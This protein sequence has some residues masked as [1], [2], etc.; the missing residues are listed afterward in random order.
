MYVLAV[1]DACYDRG[2]PLFFFK[3]PQFGSLR[4]LPK[5]YLEKI[6]QLLDE[7]PHGL[8]TQREPRKK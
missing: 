2:A 1:F 6:K 8:G 5:T 7:K 3:V 4:P